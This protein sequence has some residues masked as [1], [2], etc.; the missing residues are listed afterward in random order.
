M[1]N[2]SKLFLAIA[3]L[4][5]AATASAQHP[6][7]KPFSTSGTRQEIVFPKVKGMNVY[8][9][10]FHTHT[11]YSDGEVTPDARV[12]EAW[13]DGL[14]IIAITDHMEYRRVER[15]MYYYMKDYIREDLKAVG[16]AVNTN[17]LKQGPDNHGLLVDFNV[18]CNSA[19]KKGKDMGLL[20]V[21][22]VEITRSDRGD[23]NALFTTDN[24]KLYD[25]DLEQC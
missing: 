23:Y 6:L 2:I 17:V 21:R 10:D 4:A 11:I 20:V 16:K 8:K 7:E 12:I 13:R 24:N 5:V 1:K 19:I 9:G 22:G 3:S 18:S 14:D 25:P 15:E